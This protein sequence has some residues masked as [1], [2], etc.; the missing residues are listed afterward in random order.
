LDVE[1]R[2]RE[3]LEDTDRL[4]RTLLASLAHDFRT[5]LTVITG[6][7]EAL[8]AKSPEA[9]EAL[10]AARRLDHTMEN[11]IGA[12][13]LEDGSLV[14]Q[15]ESLDLVDIVGAAC[16]ALPPTPGTTVER[17]IPS[18]LAFVRGD[19]VLLQHVLQ[20]LLENAARHARSVI[21][22]TTAPQD[23]KIA[24]SIADDGPGIPE[25]ERTRI[26]ER[27]ARLEGSDRMRGSGLGLA[28]VK[29]FSEAMGI[30]ISLDA[31]PGGGAR[32]TLLLPCAVVG[33]IR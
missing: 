8:S 20:N 9:R 4:R 14:P 18:D 27:F 31:A 12:A 28:I 26:F 13:R 25:A 19:A 2:T 17:S 23:G 24:L 11:L 21:R 33:D 16:A 30:D 3:R 29:G 10:T 22:I 32:F 1:R 7:L 6:Q 5:P 15:L